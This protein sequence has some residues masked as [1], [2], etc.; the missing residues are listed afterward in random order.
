[1]YVTI[2]SLWLALPLAQI[3]VMGVKI[4]RNKGGHYPLRKSQLHSQMFG[5]V[6]PMGLWTCYHLGGDFNRLSSTKK[7]STSWVYPTLIS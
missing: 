4:P 5:M 1:M 3:L 7:K 2:K 6:G